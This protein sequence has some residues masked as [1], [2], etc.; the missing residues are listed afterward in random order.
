MPPFYDLC[1]TQT[2][3]T[4]YPCLPDYKPYMGSPLAQTFEVVKACS[5]A[6]FQQHDITNSLQRDYRN[7]RRFTPRLQT[8]KKVPDRSRLT[9]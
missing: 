7:S 4:E 9:A 6:K 1:D 5:V 8:P 2:L 3:I